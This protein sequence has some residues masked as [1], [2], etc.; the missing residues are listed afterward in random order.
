MNKWGDAQNQRRY[1]R[2]VNTL[3]VHISIGTQL[4]F[5]GQLKDLSL[6]SA[7]VIVKNSIYLQT[8]DEIQFSIRRDPEDSARWIEGT[9]RISRISKGEGFAIYFTEMDEGSTERLKDVV[10]EV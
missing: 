2:F 4:T 7:F 5:Q 10:G 1:Q 9:A 6:K 8:N 3:P